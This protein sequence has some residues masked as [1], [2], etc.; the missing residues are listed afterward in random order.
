MQKVFFGEV[1]SKTNLVE[2]TDIQGL[3]KYLIDKTKYTI[4][5]KYTN[6]KYHS[7]KKSENNIESNKQIL[8][9]DMI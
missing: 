2:Y 8:L 1:L 3:K 4:K 9:D 7:T 6:E 5:A